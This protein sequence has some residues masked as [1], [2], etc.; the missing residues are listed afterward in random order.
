MVVQGQ[1][2]MGGLQHCSLKLIIKA[3]PEEVM[4]HRRF[5]VKCCFHTQLYFLSTGAAAIN[6]SKMFIDR[7]RH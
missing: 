1:C 3:C 6:L 5:I 7:M 2:I 4:K